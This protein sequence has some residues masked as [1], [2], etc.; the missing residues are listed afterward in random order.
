MA[1]HF[2]LGKRK[3][4]NF[5]LPKPTQN[6][7][8]PLLPTTLQVTRET[9]SSRAGAAVFI[10]IFLPF[11]NQDLAFG[12][13][14]GWLCLWPGWR[15][16]ARQWP[17]PGSWRG[18]EQ[19]GRWSPGGWRSCGGRGPI[20]STSRFWVQTSLHLVDVRDAWREAEG[21]AFI[22][23]NARIWIFDCWTSLGMFHFHFL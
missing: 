15:Y 8:H 16:P 17:G 4:K 5:L 11:G 18:G 23:E 12:L 9:L 6:K 13:A 20:S 2:R 1:L 3:T 7:H 21:F 14:I 19:P 22:A 10:P